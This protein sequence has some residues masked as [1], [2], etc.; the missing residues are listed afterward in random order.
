MSPPLSSPSSF[1]V[2]PG[3]VVKAF[4]VAEGNQLAEIAVT[5]SVHR[6]ENQMVVVF[7][8]SLV[9]AF[10]LEPAGW[11]DIDLA[12][13]DRLDALFHRLTVKFNGAEHV[14]MVGHSHGRLL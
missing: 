4:H 10:L 3:L 7:L 1:L 5:L 14:A 2:D 11:R 6:Q 12:A 13:D 9:D 8:G